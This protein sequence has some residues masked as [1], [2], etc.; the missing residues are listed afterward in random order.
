MSNIK[1]N[2]ALDCKVICLDLKLNNKEGLENSK[3]VSLCLLSRKPGTE[4]NCRYC[5]SFSS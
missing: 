4:G 3:A 2:L 5:R 1:A